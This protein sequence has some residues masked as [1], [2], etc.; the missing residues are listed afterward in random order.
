MG[1]SN[2][3]FYKY[4]NI[5]KFDNLSFKSNCSFLINFFNDLQHKFSGLKE[6]ETNVCNTASDL[7]YELLRICFNEY[8]DLLDAKGSKIY[9][10]YD[11]INLTVDAYDYDK[12]NKEK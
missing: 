2:Y 7:Y 5:K 10:K 1:D 9:S 12:W 6:K 8:Y 4:H 11:P 3:S